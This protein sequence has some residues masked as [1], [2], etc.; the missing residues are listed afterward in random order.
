MGPPDVLD[1]VK[2]NNISKGTVGSIHPIVFI[3]EHLFQT[4]DSGSRGFDV[5]PYS[6]DPFPVC[7]GMAWVKII[8]FFVR[9]MWVRISARSNFLFSVRH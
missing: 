2:T 5:F 7:P 4:E 8:F 1:Q 6:A 3:H 9:S